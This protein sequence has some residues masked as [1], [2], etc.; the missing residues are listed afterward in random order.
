MQLARKNR[1][2]QVTLIMPSSGSQSTWGRKYF[3]KYMNLIQELKKEA[4]DLTERPHTGLSQGTFMNIYC[5]SCTGN[6]ERA[7]AWFAF[8]ELEIQR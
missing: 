1:N 7:K 5:K 6:T 4:L 2:T 8:T 3:H